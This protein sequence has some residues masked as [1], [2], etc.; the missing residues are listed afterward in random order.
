[1]SEIILIQPLKMVQIVDALVVHQQSNWSARGT[2]VNFYRWGE[3]EN[4]KT[5]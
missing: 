5:E 4:F 3:S 2:D 1:M